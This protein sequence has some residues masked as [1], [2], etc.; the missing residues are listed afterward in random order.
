[1]LWCP[2]T[3]GD[4]EKGDRKHLV[5]GGGGEGAVFGSGAQDVQGHRFGH[6]WEGGTGWSKDKE[7]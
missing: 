6:V 3:E 4:K 7:A 2:G 1:M 5:G